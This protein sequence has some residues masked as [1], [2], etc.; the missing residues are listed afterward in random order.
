MASSSRNL[1]SHFCRPKIWIKVLAGQP[2]LGRIPHGL[3]QLLVAPGVSRLVA[4]INYVLDSVSD[5]LTSGAL[6][7]WDRDLCTSLNPWI[8]LRLCTLGAIT[9]PYLRYSPLPPPPRVAWRSCKASP[10]FLYEVQQSTWSIPYFST[11]RSSFTYFLHHVFSTYI[12]YFPD[13]L[14]K[15]GKSFT[16]FIIFHIF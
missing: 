13:V 10:S 3:L 2:P 12:L 7:T 9:H 8:P 11:H 15:V 16:Y 4:A 14:N 5:A 1:F 6:L